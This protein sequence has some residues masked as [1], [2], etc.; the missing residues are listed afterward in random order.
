MRGDSGHG[1]HFGVGT[2]EYYFNS[3]HRILILKFG[4]C[5]L[6]YGIMQFDI[7]D[8]NRHE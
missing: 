1:N 8:G 2:L 3:E 4:H 7:A 5:L 6:Y